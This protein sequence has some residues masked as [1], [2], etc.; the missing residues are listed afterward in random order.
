[1]HKDR[2]P[3]SPFFAMKNLFLLRHAKSSWANPG[4]DDFDRPLNDRGKKNIPLMGA[5]L[6]NLFIIPDLII[7][8]PAVRAISTSKK[9]ATE[10]GYDTQH[11]IIDLR[12]YEA[13]VKD[14]LEVVNGISN[15]YNDVFLVGHNPGF[16]RFAN[17]LCDAGID[18][19]PTCGIVQINFE[20]DNWNMITKNSGVLKYYDYPKNN[21]GF[22]KLVEANC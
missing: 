22:D 1:M 2:R 16:T 20:L 19:I 18:N 14:L 7:S 3:R 15:D 17:Y 4:Q 21:A 13:N 5:V 6:K 10:I 8:S 9:M 12:I 11:I